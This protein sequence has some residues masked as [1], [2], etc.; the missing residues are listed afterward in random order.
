MK[1]TKDKHFFE[2]ER[3]CIAE[4]F[5]FE[6]SWFDSRHFDSFGE[7]S[8]SAAQARLDDKTDAFKSAQKQLEQTQLELVDART[9]LAASEASGMRVLWSDEEEEEMREAGITLAMSQPREMAQM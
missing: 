4:Q 1:N 5:V 2:S 3:K 9:K 6:M 8:C 7:I